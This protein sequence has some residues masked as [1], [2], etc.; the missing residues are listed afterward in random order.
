MADD[1]EVILIDATQAAREKCR[2]DFVW[3]YAG[4]RRA[5][6][7]RATCDDSFHYSSIVSWEYGRVAG[8]STATARRHLRKLVAAGHMEE[9]PGW[10]GVPRF[11]FP[12]RVHDVIG[13]QVIAEL[14]AQGLPFDKDAK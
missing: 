14:R 3:N 10:S 1:L 12:R 7:Y 6:H 2:S 4:G 8:T 11:R 5:I 13:A 9:L